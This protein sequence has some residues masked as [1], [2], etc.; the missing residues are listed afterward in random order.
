MSPRLDLYSEVVSLGLGHAIDATHKCP[1]AQKGSFQAC[2]VTYDEELDISNISFTDDRGAWRNYEENPESCVVPSEK[3]LRLLL[4]KTDKNSEVTINVGA[5]TL[6]GTY[7]SK[8]LVGRCLNTRTVSLRFDQ[9]HKQFKDQLCEWVVERARFYKRF[10]KT[11]ARSDQE[12]SLK[13]ELSS[14]ERD[15]AM[16]LKEV[17]L[18]DDGD[19]KL[20]V[21][22][23]MEEIARKEEVLV[24]LCMEFIAKFHV[25]HYVSEIKLGAAEF[26]ISKPDNGSVMLGVSADASSSWNSFSRSKETRRLGSFNRKEN[27]MTKEAVLSIKV[28]PITNL[29]KI[30]PQLQLATRRALKQ[31]FKE[32]ANHAPS[33]NFNDSLH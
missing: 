11:A 14:A 16:K 10:V 12:D 26:Q 6:R 18:H 28:Q 25:T 4:E 7:D 29:I 21:D 30:K 19:Q 23:A 2:P 3:D 33:K 27:E 5:E 17:D 8:K 15:L 13:A 9:E 20:P 22:R 24:E 1:W 31:Y 32:H